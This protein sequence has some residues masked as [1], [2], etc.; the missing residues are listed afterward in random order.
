MA[1]YHALGEDNVKTLTN[2]LSP[3]IVES[4]VV[5]N[6]KVFQKLGIKVIEDTEFERTQMIFRRKGG[7]ARRYKQGST[8]KSK[9]GYMEE[10]K[11]VVVQAW[12]RY[13]ENLQNFREKQPFIISGSNKTY[14]APVSEF[15]L[16]NIGKQYAGDVLSNLFFGKEALGEDH[17]MALYDGYWTKIDQLINMGK[18]SKGLMNLVDCSPIQT[19]P[20]TEAGENY[21]AFVEWVEGWHP[22]LRNAEHV[23]VYM[24]PQQKRLII[25]SYMRKFTG[26]QSANAGNESFKFV[27]MENIELVSHAIIG[28]GDRMIAT[29]PD[30]LQFGLDKEDDWNSVN[31]THDP[32]D[33]N[34][35]IFQVQSTQGVRILDT[36]GSSFCVSNGTASPIEELNGDYQKN[37]LT[38]TSND[39]TMGKVQVSPQKDEYT[40]GETITLTPQAEGSHT[41]VAWSDGAT[42][43]PRSIVYSGYPTVLQA[44]FKKND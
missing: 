43:S 36:A 1:K 3:D 44:I 15:I 5:E 11:L 26:L 17:P 37:T 16:R 13:Y 25:H 6:Y 9:L 35:L 28:K 39:T 33:M 27:G 31:M 19:G 41:F 29:V 30:N 34:V 10:S 42:I 23:L 2:I 20:E 12:A 40:E 38:V 14:N 18:I 7:E 32:H 21:D 22:S 24:A 8:L 4:P